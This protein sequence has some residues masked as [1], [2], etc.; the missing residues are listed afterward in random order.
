MDQLSQLIAIAV[1]QTVKETQPHHSDASKNED[2][3]GQER[4]SPPK[5]R[6]EGEGV[7]GDESRTIGNSLADQIEEPREEMRQMK[8]K[9]GLFLP[10][11]GSPFTQVI[12]AGQSGRV[13]WRQR[14]WR[15]LRLV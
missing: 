13:L 10:R 8:N 2:G 15:T 4:E 3:T 1:Q 5:R 7:K 6:E 12:Q 11:K 9:E 14:S